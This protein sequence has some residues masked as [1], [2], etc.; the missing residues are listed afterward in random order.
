MRVVPAEA[1]RLGLSWVALLWQLL[2][3]AGPTGASGRPGVSPQPGVP[4]VCV[5]GPPGGPAPCHPQWAQQ[6]F[7]LPSPG[8]HS[9]LCIPDGMPPG[10]GPGHTHVHVP[11][12]TCT[13]THVHTQ[14]TC[15]RQ[16]R[17]GLAPRCFDSLPELDD[18][19]PAVGKLVTCEVGHGGIGTVFVAEDLHTIGS[20][21]RVATRGPGQRG[22]EGLHQI[23][24]APG[25]HHDVIGVA[26]EDDH[27][28]GV[29]QAWGA[30]E[31]LYP[32][33]SLA[34][35]SLLPQSADQ[36]VPVVPAG[37]LTSCSP[38]L[39]TLTPLST[40]RPFC[41]CPPRLL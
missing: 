17:L 14:A 32:G 33:S 7:L 18:W 41:C 4:A 19:G 12:R 36:A 38:H 6:Q 13:Y 15:R 27:H 2:S 22:G 40:T 20:V 23:I 5:P 16:D 1:K 9:L 3:L 28:G 34:S 10:R 39:L 26:V 29:A 31:S 37:P 35:P 21:P 25:Q 11:V 30:G 24:E 8:R